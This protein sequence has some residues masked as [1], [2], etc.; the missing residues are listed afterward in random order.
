[1]QKDIWNNN[2][3]LPN[4]DEIKQALNFPPDYIE[5]TIKL[6]GKSAH[7]FHFAKTLLSS[8]FKDLSEEEII[9]YLVRQGAEKEI[10]KLSHIWSK[11]QE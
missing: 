11:I 4:L 7:R 9:A 1:M 6:Q 10:E 3:S 5:M 2:V 8:V